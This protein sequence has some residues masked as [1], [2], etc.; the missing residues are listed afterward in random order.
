MTAFELKLAACIFMLLDHI[1]YCADIIWM[2]VIGRLAFPIFAFLIANG[3]RHTGNVRKYIMRLFLFALLSEPCFDRFSS[4]TWFC[5]DYQNVMWTLLFGL[6]CLIVRD[7]LRKR[8]QSGRWLYPPVLLSICVV[9]CLANTD[10]AAVGVLTVVA[11]GTDTGGLQRLSGQNAP[12]CKLENRCGREAPGRTACVLFVLVTC[13]QPL[14]YTVAVLLES[15]CGVRLCELPLLSAIFPK[16][17]TEWDIV[18]ICRIFAIGPLLLYNGRHGI[19]RKGIA[20]AVCQYGFY[21]F[22]PLHMLV[23]A[24]IWK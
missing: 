14:L 10:Y 1:G 15:V 5:P 23:L 8:S 16:K 21:A 3:Y 17:L 11:F 18:N 24:F 4:G 9:S 7:E 19:P 12:V 6:S 22:Y 20:A 2:R 13:L